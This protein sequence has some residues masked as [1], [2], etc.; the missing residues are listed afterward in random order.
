MSWF[1]NNRY[2]NS[3]VIFGV[4]TLVGWAANTQWYSNQEAR[5]TR[6]QGGVARVSQPIDNPI[7]SDKS[8]GPKPTIQDS[9]KTQPQP[10]QLS[11]ENV[12]GLLAE[13]RAN[14]KYYTPMRDKELRN[15][16]YETPGMAKELLE[17]VVDLDDGEAKRDLTALL[18][19]VRLLKHVSLD[20]LVIEEIKKG[21]RRS[22]WLNVL[23]EI[24]IG[25][26]EGIEYVSEELTFMTED[27][28]ILAAIKALS[29][30]AADSHLPVK[31]G[32]RK[33]LIANVHRHLGAANDDVKSAAV[34]A[35]ARYPTDN[36]ERSLL[37]ASNDP[38]PKVRQ[39]A[40]SVFVNKAPL[41][42]ALRAKAMSSL[43]DTSLDMYERLNIANSL[44]GLTLSDSD[45]ILV[46]Q[47]SNELRGVYD[48]F[49]ENQKR[50][51]QE[52]ASDAT[53]VW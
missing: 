31:P 52:R 24:G 12:T 41:S 10:P 35:L 34:Y 1:S 16:V 2:L 42:Q 15:L 43:Q 47:I 53:G 33:R 9:L 30:P 20:S 5:Q 17:K 14:N 29:G 26:V 18:L 19:A 6:Y 32:V 46:T 40:R 45:K 4:A 7:E 48:S 50:D 44:A 25:S 49:D 11:S 22:D 3:A 8:L 51:F 39:A 27:R 23:G 21:D 38:S 28:D 36:L 13:R 37:T